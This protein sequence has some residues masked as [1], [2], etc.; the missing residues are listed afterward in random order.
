MDQQQNIV[1]VWVKWFLNVLWELWGEPILIGLRLY[2]PKD[3]TYGR[4]EIPF[5]HME[6][7]LHDNPDVTVNFYKA[8]MPN[9]KDWVWYQVW[10]DKAAQRATGRRADMVFCLS[11]IHI[12]EPTRPY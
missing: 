10:E 8:I 11:L 3:R 4:S 7:R 1:L 9:G 2:E 12:S 5:S 6:K